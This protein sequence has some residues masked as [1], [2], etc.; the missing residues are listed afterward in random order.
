VHNTDDKLESQSDV[1]W[2]ASMAAVV[3]ALAGC[4]ETQVSETQL[5]YAPARARTCELQF[6]SGMDGGVDWELLGNVVLADHGLEDPAAPANLAAIRAMAC[7]LG[8]TAVAVMTSY[9]HTTSDG[10]RD[11]SS[12]DYL[13]LR[14]KP[15]P[16]P[17]IRF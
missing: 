1:M 3:I 15:A 12:I 8:G 9:V 11:G 7:E 5:V 14:P 17:P 2:I 6:L 4:A 13:V 16:R 10:D